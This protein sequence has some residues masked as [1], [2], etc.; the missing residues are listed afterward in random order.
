LQV[1]LVRNAFHIRKRPPTSWLFRH[2][3][4]TAGHPPPLGIRFI[5]GTLIVLCLD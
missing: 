4:R 3:Y 2:A 5:D 1:F